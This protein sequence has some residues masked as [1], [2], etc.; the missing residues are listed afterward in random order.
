VGRKVETGGLRENQRRK[1]KKKE[2][3]ER[4]KERKKEGR[5]ERKGKKG[6]MAGHLSP[7]GGGVDGLACGQ[8]RQ[9]MGQ[10]KPKQEGC[11]SSS[12]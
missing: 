7:A 1:E 3:N 6:E 8:W 4:M 9:H 10:P 5:K 2:G 11:K 12:K